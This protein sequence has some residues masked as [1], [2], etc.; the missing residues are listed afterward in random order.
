M[1]L[2]IDEIGPS[3]RFVTATINRIPRNTDPRD[4]SNGGNRFT[5]RDTED[6][7]GDPVGAGVGSG[8][9]D[10][11]AVNRSGSFGGPGEPPPF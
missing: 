11:W 8:S 7:S 3:L 10:P 6:G 9:G 4:H 1:E 5:G 2:E